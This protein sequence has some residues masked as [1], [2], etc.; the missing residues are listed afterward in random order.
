ML[1]LE[2]STIENNVRR[3]NDMTICKKLMQSIRLKS[4]EVFRA[5]IIFDFI[6]MMTGFFRF[7]KAANIF[8]YYKPIFFNISALACIRM[9]RRPDKNITATLFSTTFPC[10]IF[11][12][13]IHSQ[14]SQSH[15]LL[16]LFRNFTAFKKMW[17]ALFFK[18]FKTAE[19]RLSHFFSCFWRMF[20]T[21]SC[22][23]VI[24]IIFY[25]NLTKLLSCLRV[26]IAL[27]HKGSMF[28]NDFWSSF[29]FTSFHNDYILSYLNYKCNRFKLLNLN[30]L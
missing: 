11:R 20:L 28:L 29:K 8:F 21:F 17:L 12:T 23:R 7:K 24:L 5:I 18:F 14:F 6:D 16:L 26:C 22:R 13:N 15:F 25:H 4:H 9:M 10:R 2:F 19:H 30:K 1:R 27:Q 3:F